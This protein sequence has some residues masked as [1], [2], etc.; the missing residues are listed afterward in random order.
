MDESQKQ[1]GLYVPVPFEGQST[2]ERLYLKAPTKTVPQGSQETQ[3]K[4][5]GV[6]IMASNFRVVVWREGEIVHLKLVGDFDGSSACEL[7]ETVKDHS[8]GG[9]RVLICTNS[10]KTVYPF[11][12]HVL[13][14]NSVN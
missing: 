3:T 13:E 5:K 2:R 1:E 9:H 11:G 4:G 10:L 14:K 12:V 8:V 7:Y 6:V